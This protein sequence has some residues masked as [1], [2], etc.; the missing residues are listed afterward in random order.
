[1]ALEIRINLLNREKSNGSWHSFPLDLI[2]EKY[3]FCIDFASLKED[4]LFLKFL[5]EL[6]QSRLEIIPNL[7]GAFYLK[8]IDF[9]EDI[10]IFPGK[11]RRKY[12]VSK[13]KKYALDHNQRFSLGKNI[14][15]FINISNK[16]YE[17]KNVNINEN[18]QIDDGDLDNDSFNENSIYINTPSNSKKKNN[19]LENNNNSDNNGCD[20]SSQIILDEVIKE[21]M[22]HSIKEKNINENS[23]KRKSS[24]TDS[25]LDNTLN[26]S[27][28]E[29]KPVSKIKVSINDN[30]KKGT[31]TNS[32]D[33]FFL[34]KSSS[35][36][37]KDIF[38]PRNIMKK[39]LYKIALSGFKLNAKEIMDLNTLGIVLNS[40]DENFEFLIIVIY[41]KLI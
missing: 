17:I 12:K 31:S 22:K 26:T 11:G 38:S 16:E 37:V 18:T 6:N 14:M 1:M 2:N 10:F 8:N 39:P 9:D 24:S 40:D 13:N 7:D 29:K 25:I 3:N 27:E 36:H 19:L 33:Y 32:S 34:T 35:N 20:K 41:I 15:C 28:S 23:L 4:D 21:K 5:K 30:D